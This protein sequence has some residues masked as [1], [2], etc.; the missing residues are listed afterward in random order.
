MRRLGPTVRLT[1]TLSAGLLTWGTGWS[2]AVASDSDL[3]GRPGPTLTA[4]DD[5]PGG[6]VLVKDLVLSWTSVSGATV[7]RVQMSPNGDWTNNRV[8]LPEGGRTVATRYA[9]R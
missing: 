4:P 1:A 5:D 8:T 7:Y 6:D 3:A 9:H 2:A